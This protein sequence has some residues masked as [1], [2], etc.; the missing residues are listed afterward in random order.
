M[1]NHLFCA[2]AFALVCATAAE[3]LRLNQ[4]QVIG[5]HNSYHAGIAPSEAKLM[6]Q[7]DPAAFDSLDYSHKDLA[8]QLDGGVRQIEIDV[9]A[10]AAG[11]RYANPAGPRLVAEAGLPAD[12][13]YKFASFMTKPGLKVLHVED[14]DYRSTCPTFVECLKVVRAWSK[15]HPRHIPI[16]ILVETKEVKAE[17]F[18]T[19]AFD[20]LDAEIRSVFEPGELVTPDVARGKH[21]TLNEAIRTAGW[22]ALDE[23]R[24]KVVF[25]MDQRRAGAA[26]LKGHASLRGRVMFTNAVPGS[27]DA[28]FTEQNDG[29]EATIA[30]LVKQG[31]L[32]RTRSDVETKQARTGDTARRDLALRSGAQMVSTDYPSFEP[33]RWTGYLVSLPA[34]A[35]ARCN[36]VL[37]ATPCTID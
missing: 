20:A 6:A 35:V 37:V 14:Y 30:G 22:P 34:G 32:V 12:P 17:P 11:G 9:F 8:A 21:A 19:A 29:D 27:P 28:A 3:P 26:Y 7:R 5:T 10:D 2:A 13:P 16:F 23:C 33:S 36:P 4:I 31:Y 1:M 15:A 24:G 25:L 18:T